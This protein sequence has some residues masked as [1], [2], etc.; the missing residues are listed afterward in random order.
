MN[1]L[2]SMSDITENNITTT[3]TLRPFGCEL[4]TL[5]QADG[6]AIWKSGGTSVLASVHGPAAPR[7]ASLELPKAQV[8]FVVAGRTSDIISTDQEEWEPLLRRVLE[9][10][11][12]VQQYP[13]T[14]IQ[15]VCHVLS[16]DGSVLAACLHAAVAALMDAGIALRQLPTAVAIRVTCQSE[17]DYHLSL[18]PDME[19]EQDTDRSLQDTPS[20]LICLIVAQASDSEKLAVLAAHCVGGRAPVAVWPTAVGLAERARPAL[21]NFMKMAL[22][23]KM[24][25]RNKAD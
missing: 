19:K 22:Q 3:A 12:Q 7:Q 23:Q 6:S 13:R 15:I 8:S 2:N 16:N 24:Q 5:E 11:I 10:S 18:D 1:P 20:S 14:V 4:T 21:T 17:H 25:T 9:R